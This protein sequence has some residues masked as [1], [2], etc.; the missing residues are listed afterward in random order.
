MSIHGLSWL[1]FEL[2]KLRIFLT[3]IRIRIQLLILLRI[4]TLIRLP[5]GQCGFGSATLPRGPIRTT[6]NMDQHTVPNRWYLG[7]I[8]IIQMKE[9]SYQISVTPRFF[10]FV[11]FHEKFVLPWKIPSSSNSHPAHSTK[12]FQHFVETY[13]CKELFFCQ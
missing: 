11:D 12:Q 8:N 10:K 4:R 7:T 9:R 2:L 5:S 3:L 1:H 6:P 13:V